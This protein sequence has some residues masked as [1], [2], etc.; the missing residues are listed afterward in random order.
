MLEFQIYITKKSKVLQYEREND[1]GIE[2]GDLQSLE[3]RVGIW[4]DRSM[5]GGTFKVGKETD[6]YDKCTMITGL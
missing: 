6:N 3:C 4:Q 2:D 1:L 5:Y